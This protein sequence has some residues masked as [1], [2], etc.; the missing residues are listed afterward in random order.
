MTPSSLYLQWHC[1]QIRS[2]DEI[3]PIRTPAFAFLQD[4]IQPIRDSRSDLWSLSHYDH[5]V[6]KELYKRGGMCRF[7][8]E[9]VNEFSLALPYFICLNLNH[10]LNSLS[11]GHVT[12]SL[13]TAMCCLSPKRI[14]CLSSSFQHGNLGNFFPFGIG[15]IKIVG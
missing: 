7:I 14:F 8:W 6:P 9:T 1:F 4:S 12:E 11:S 2:Q 5:G 3:S 10:F 13:G 15:V